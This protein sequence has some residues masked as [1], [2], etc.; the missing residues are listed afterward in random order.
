MVLS[1]GSLTRCSFDAT[2]VGIFG[3]VND[4]VQPETSPYVLCETCHQDV[5]VEHEPMGGYRRETHEN[6]GAVA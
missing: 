4:T 6:V 1:D 5:G 3:H 2:G